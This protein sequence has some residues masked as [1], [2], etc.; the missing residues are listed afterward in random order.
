MTNATTC[1]LCTREVP[2]GQLRSHVTEENDVI[3]GY[4]IRAIRRNNPG[5]VADDGSCRKCWDYYRDL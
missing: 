5:W 4:I 1:P 2:A 3:R